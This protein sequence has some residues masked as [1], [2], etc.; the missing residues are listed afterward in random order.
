[1][2]KPHLNQIFDM[3][4]DD[5]GISGEGVGHIEGFTVFIDGALP[6][7]VIQAQLVQSKRHFGR[8]NLLAIHQKSPSRVQPPCPLFDRC[9]G[10][11][12]MHINYDQQLEFKRDRVT[13]A[14]RYI[15]KISDANVA[16]CLPS[17]SPLAYRNKIQLIVAPA[18]E[19]IAIGLYA[20]GSHDVVEINKCYIHC[21]QGEEIF[22]NI[23]KIIKQST[24]EPYIAESGEGELR[25]ILIK[26]AVFTRQSLVVLV[27]NG[28]ASTRIKKAAQEIIAQSP[29]VKGVVHNSNTSRTNVILGNEYNLLCGVPS[30]DEQLCG[31]HFKISAASFFQVNPAQAENLYKKALEF[32]ELKD[33]DVALD[34]Y[35][36]V[37]TL[38]LLM[39]KQ[40]KHVLGIE[41]VKEAIEDAKENAVR[42]GITN[43][44]FVCE[45]TED[46]LKGFN[47]KID[48]IFLNPPRKG[49]EESVLKCI[50]KI[51][52]KKIV[53]ISCDPAT[54]A[55]DI[56]Q[57]CTMGYKLNIIQPYDM[58]PQTAHVE[59][60][61]QLTLI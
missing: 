52:P 51:K 18:K 6:G 46:Y 42:N 57:L 2:L 17:P 12:I 25:H 35:C 43:V 40:A 47:K 1:M 44:S 36:G 55:R 7:E 45:N 50:A 21:P 8:A 13:K 5:L 20:K 34:A 19:G 32:A 27:T 28:P 30:I 16:P 3:T 48:V 59:C 29:T 60:V 58:F 15:G 4:I 61:A 39:A 26:T 38:T 53:Y 11:Q 33:N 22:Q 41:N 49:C 10:C 24:I 37:G 23:N 56:G 31:L 54:L 9:G 14:I